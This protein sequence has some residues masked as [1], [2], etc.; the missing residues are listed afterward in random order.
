MTKD[1]IKCS[2]ATMPTNLAPK[3]SVPFIWG[4]LKKQQEVDRTD[5]VEYLMYLRSKFRY[6]KGEK[7]ILDLN[8]NLDSI[9]EHLVFIGVAEMSGTKLKLIKQRGNL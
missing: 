4:I 7:K 6:K 9:I 5:L 8:S 2:I 3:E 1:H